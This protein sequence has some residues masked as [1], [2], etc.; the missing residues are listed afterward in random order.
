MATATERIPNPEETPWVSVPE[1]GRMLCGLGRRASYEAAR[2]GEIPTIRVGPR[3]M[4]VPTAQL[5]A[6][7]GLDQ[8]S[9][10]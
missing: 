1:A 9:A 6:L 8:G 4:V 2:R 5:R 7:L 3:R 10:A